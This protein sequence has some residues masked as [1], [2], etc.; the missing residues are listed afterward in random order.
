M[1]FDKA[2][3]P[4]S[5]ENKWILFWEEN[6]LFKADATSDRP[7]FCIVIP[8]PNV[9]GVLH[10]GH[11]LVDVLQD[12][13]TRFKRMD[14][15]EALWIP[16]TDHAGIATQTVVERH[17][18]ETL[19]QRRSD[20]PRETFL[21]HVWDWK[22]KSEATILEQIKRLGCSCD[23][24]RY[25]F[26]MDSAC[27]LAVRTIFKKLFDEGYIYRGDY[28]VN[29]DPVTQTALADDEVEY[30]DKEGFLWTFSYPLANGSGDVHIATT[31]PETMLGDTALAVSPKDTRYEH[32][33]GQRAIL[34]ILQREIP[35]IAD[36]FVDPSFGT[37]IV[38][39]TPAHDPNDYKM[40]LTHHLPMINIMHPNGSLNEQAGPFA[41]MSREEARTAVVQEMQ[42]L[43]RLVKVERHTLRIGVSYRSK[44]VIEPMLS[45][46]WF[47]KMTPFVQPMR[48]AVTTQAVKLVPE[49][50]QN[51]YFHWIDNLRDWCISRQLWW[52][53]RIPVWHHVSDS[54]RMI[55]Y[56]GEGIPPEVAADP[57][58]WEQ[59][60]DVLDTW[61]SSALWPLSTLGWPQKTLDFEKFYPTS[62][63]VTGHDILFFWV[64]RMIMMGQY[65]TGSVPFHTAFLHGLIYGRSYWR[66]RAQGGIDY[67]RGE[68]KR[69]YD[70]GEPLA[71]G[72]QA[73]WEKLSKSK[74]NVIDPLELIEEY[75]TDAVRMAL[76][77]I[78]NQSPQIDLDR[79][80]FE[81]FKNFANK[82]WNG[83]R[84]VLMHLEDLP[85]EE[86]SLPLTREH[87]QLED[88]WILSG[89]NRVIL[90]VRE[91][92]ENY[93]FDRAA[94]QAYNFFWKEFCAYYVEFSKPTLLGTDL[95]E[96]RIK[97][98]VLLVV[99]LNMVRL[100]HPMAP[101][102]TEELFQILK[103]RFATS[104][105]TATGYLKD[106][107]EA[108]LAIA[109]ARAPYPKVLDPKD[110]D[111]SVEQEFS[112][113]EEVIYTLR[114]IRGEMKIPPHVATE[115]YIEGDFPQAYVRLLH[116]LIHISKVH[117]VTQ[118]P[119]LTLGATATVGPLRLH[120]PLPQEMAEQEKQRLQK[121]K[122]QLQHQSELIS[123]LLHNP[124]FLAKA[125]EELVTKKKVEYQA[126]LEELSTL[127][128]KLKLM[129]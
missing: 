122:L 33:I 85:Q 78:A 97:Q 75:G 16:G 128:A 22:A 36:P 76:C 56:E 77:S 127:E 101:F 40:G 41:G 34:P 80:R 31:R 61:F 9:T 92:F 83:A 7:P 81:E 109:C 82:V 84:F 6:A 66:E 120:L 70:L 71:K 50:W 86:L 121:Q 1:S 72:V 15:F 104:Q 68:E 32:L 94:E 52:G 117:L 3:D 113:L 60:P 90:Q 125:K 98:K 115:V 89:L 95:P 13:L 28:L 126:V 79:R 11:A 129:P 5:T 30:E 4:K 12:V 2:Y 35:I 10:M 57:N 102:I 44:A 14:G 87:L 105:V 99:L 116:A 21:Q 48:E 100:L 39:V 42:A 123:K 38:K 46:Q 65:V 108:L 47:V 53:H 119:Q 103:K 67:I 18:I 8:P 69:R 19:G 124:E 17:L 59:D 43:G 96:K 24:S 55:C 111:I 106:V 26:T 58:S 45:K 112:R 54:T 107:Q 114:N 73:K 88:R 93:Q 74:G 25:R 49:N 51:T 29:W 62:V 118:A 64:A 20:M 91:A 27:N 37:G 63:L 110:I 23:F